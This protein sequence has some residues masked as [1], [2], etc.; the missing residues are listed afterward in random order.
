MINDEM[1]LEFYNNYMPSETPTNEQAN[2]LV[3]KFIELLDKL[4]YKKEDYINIIDNCMDNVSSMQYRDL[5]PI[6]S[7]FEAKRFCNGIGI[8]GPPW[9]HF[10][11]Y[12]SMHLEGNDIKLLEVGAGAGWIKLGLKNYG[13]EMLATDLKEESTHFNTSF[14]VCSGIEN[15]DAK[16]SI[17]KYHDKINAVLVSWAPYDE[18][19]QTDVLKLCIK[20]NLDLYVIGEDMEGCTGDNEFWDI[21]YDNNLEIIDWLVGYIPFDGM[22]DRLFK[23]NIR[24]GVMSI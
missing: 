15:L 19:M 3:Y 2:R 8:W 6:I 7:N 24:K 13:Y 5:Y 23:V 11:K 14:K 18:P 20:Y 22:H 4:N 21:V 17:E 12:F 16:S 10:C 1:F 9:K